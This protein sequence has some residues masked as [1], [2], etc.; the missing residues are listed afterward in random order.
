[1]KIDRQPVMQLNDYQIQAI[2][3]ATYPPEN[4]L[5]YTGLKLAGEAGEYTD[6]LGKFFRGDYDELPREALALELGDVLWYVAAC[7][8]ELQYTLRQIADMN[9]DKLNSRKKRGTLQGDGDNR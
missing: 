2:D 7:A 6:K 3:L 8:K 4:G 9:L 1:M 5:V